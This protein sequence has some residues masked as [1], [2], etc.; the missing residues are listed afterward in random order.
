MSTPTKKK[1]K[2][3]RLSDIE[4]DEISLVRCGANQ[5]AKVVFWKSDGPPPRDLPAAI[6]EIDGK[7][8]IVLKT[9]EGEDDGYAYADEDGQFSDND[10]LDPD[11]DD[12]F[13]DED[14]Q[15]WI[16]ED[17]FA[18]KH[19]LILGDLPDLPDH[20]PEEATVTKELTKQAR[21][22]SEL[23]KQASDVVL[24]MVDEAAEE[25]SLAE[26]KAM[27]PEHGFRSFTADEAGAIARVEVLK[28]NPDLYDDYVELRRTS[29]PGMAKSLSLVSKSDD[30]TKRV[31][32]KAEELMKTEAGKGLTR[33]AAIA[34]VFATDPD[35]AKDYRA[36]RMAAARASS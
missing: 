15:T 35:V 28:A 12:E 22:T 14:A 6:R 25:F 24:D 34:K 33:I 19:G 17:D 31:H 3:N 10:E 36:L 16:S 29:K 9:D 21:R 2:A 26:Y 30:L 23:A 1:R 7:Y 27:H 13:W 32:A 8:E 18:A 5:G 4:T 11:A 20:V